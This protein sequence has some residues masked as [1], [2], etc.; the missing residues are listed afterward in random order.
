M[1][2]VYDFITIEDIRKE[3]IF[4]LKEKYSHQGE[5]YGF[6]FFEIQSIDEKYIKHFETNVKTAFVQ[7]IFEKDLS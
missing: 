1:V 7:Y 5:T 6:I 3:N 4:N 2:Q